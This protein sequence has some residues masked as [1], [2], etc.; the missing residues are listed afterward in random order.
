MLRLEIRLFSRPRG[1]KKYV[2]LGV[3]FFNWEFFIY[4]PKFNVILHVLIIKDQ[5]NSSF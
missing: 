5:Y 3:T 2:F 4:D 1:S